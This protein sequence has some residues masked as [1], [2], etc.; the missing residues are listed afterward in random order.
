MDGL[1]SA[2][3]ARSRFEPPGPGRAMRRGTGP[4]RG[5]PGPGQVV[6]LPLGQRVA[7]SSEG[8]QIQVM[9]LALTLAA[10]RAEITLTGQLPAVADGGARQL[11][12]YELLRGSAADDRGATY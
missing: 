11:C 8:G 4:R 5:S 2:L 9:L 1:Q 7:I 3:A 12:W 10:D 6:A